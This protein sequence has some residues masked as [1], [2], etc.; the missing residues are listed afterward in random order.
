MTVGGQ[1]VSAGTGFIAVRVERILGLR[2]AAAVDA[3][4]LLRGQKFLFKLHVST[5]EKNGISMNFYLVRGTVV[6]IGGLAAPAAEG[7]ATVAIRIRFD[8]KRVTAVRIGRV[9]WLQFGGGIRRS[10]AFR[11]AR[12]RA[13]RRR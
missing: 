11:T 8:V 7:G 9:K 4:L 10:V 6:S 2:Q 3:L 13:G 12:D 1:N 5:N